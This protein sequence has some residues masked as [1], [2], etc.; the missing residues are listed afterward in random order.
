MPVFLKCQTYR[1]L[2]CK[3]NQIK[4]ISTRVYLKLTLT[5]EIQLL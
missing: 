3:N 2:F 5:Y 1:L 4:K